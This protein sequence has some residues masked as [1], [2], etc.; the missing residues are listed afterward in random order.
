MNNQYDNWS[1]SHSWQHLR[2]LTADWPPTTTLY[3]LWSL[4]STFPPLPSSWL[5]SSTCEWWVMN[6]HSVA[7]L[8]AS[9]SPKLIPELIEHIFLNNWLWL[10]TFTFYEGLIWTKCRLRTFS[11]AET[12][13]SVL[14]SR[15]GQLWAGP[16]GSWRRFWSESGLRVANRFKLS[17]AEL[18][19]NSQS[20]ALLASLCLWYKLVAAPS[21]FEYFKEGCLMCRNPMQM[22]WKI[23]VPAGT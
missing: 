2:G 11:L 13:S 17:G 16:P 6:G 20:L 9:F 15:A 12:S 18:T 22:R 10:F 8:T 21:M 5:D 7:T 4:W 1:H 19:S 14:C 3:E 23:R